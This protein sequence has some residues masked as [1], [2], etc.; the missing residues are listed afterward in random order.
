[1]KLTSIRIKQFKAVDDSGT[2]KLG[3]LTAFVGYNGTGKSSVI[4]ACELLRNYALGGIEAAISPWYGFEHILWQGAERKKQAS[5]PFYTQPLILEVAGKVGKSPWR[6]ALEI[7]E[8]AEE[9]GKYPAR[10]V[11]P[12]REFL[13]VGKQEAESLFGSRERGRPRAGS[14]ILDDNKEVDFRKWMF[15]NLNPH[16]IGQPRRR[17]EGRGE[18]PLLKTGANLADILKSFLDLDP[19]GFDGMIQALLPPPRQSP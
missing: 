6:A 12:K 19:E 11:L 15:L 10:T 8:L 16:D 7:G 2:L 13:K 18:E 3:P 17:P 1:M 14:Q 5:S 9:A 4:E